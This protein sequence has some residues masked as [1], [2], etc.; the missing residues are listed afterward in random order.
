MK[1]LF[2]PILLLMSSLAIA[3]FS[4]EEH[5]GDPLVDGQTVSYGIYGYGGAELDFYVNNLSTTDQIFMKLQFVSA[6]N[7]DGSGVEACFGLCYTDLVFGASYPPGTEVVTI[8]PGQNQGGIGDHIVNLSDGGGN[9]IEYVFRWY[10]VDANGTP[11]GDDLSITY[12]YDPNLGLQG[13]EVDA[14]ALAT[15]VNHVLPVQVNEPVSLKLYDL[16]GRHIS[17]QKLEAGTHQIAVGHLASQMY[18]AILE[19]A[20]GHRSVIKFMKK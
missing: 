3:Q 20:S 8:E 12:R 5:N 11:F 6:V 1:N 18:L 14:F 2:T 16:Q 9:P 13:Q 7:D 17:Q 15:N 4:V 10:Q 19:D